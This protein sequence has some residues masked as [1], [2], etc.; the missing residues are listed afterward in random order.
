[1]QQKPY[2]IIFQGD[3]ITDC[4][5]DYSCQ[6]PN[7]LLGNGYVALLAAALLSEYPERNIEIYNRGVS[8]NRVVDLYSRWKIDTLNLRPDFLSILIGVNDTWHEFELNNGVEVPRYQ[9]IYR[10]LLCWTKETL[11]QCK[12]LL[13]APFAA[14][15]GVVTESWRKDIAARQKVVRELAN[16]FDL[17]YVPESWLE[18]A[19]Q[20]AP[21]NYWL[22]DGVHPTYA[23]HARLAQAWREVAC[24]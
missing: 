20:D 14:T 7:Q 18:K 19:L 1:M 21:A 22:Q 6:Q 2:K 9:R 15:F 3:S 5:R 4:N 10:E 16:E 8:G 17:L 13:I 23:G 12:I 24:L 11:P